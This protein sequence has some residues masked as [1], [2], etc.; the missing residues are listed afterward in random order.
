[1]PF[2]T[3]C[4]VAALVVSASGRAEDLMQVYREAQQND[5]AIA[6]ARANWEATQER[7]PQARAGL[8]PNVALSASAATKHARAAA[9]KRIMVGTSVKRASQGAKGL[10]PRG[11]S[12]GTR[13]GRR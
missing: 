1:M 10:S 4:A 2:T 3:A 11:R 6:A 13:S 7:V 12:R 8:L 5:P 9:W